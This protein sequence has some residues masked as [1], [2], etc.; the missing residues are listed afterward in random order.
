MLAL[1][2]QR[3]LSD[4]VHLGCFIGGG[5]HVGRFGKQLDLQR[6]QVTEDPRDRDH[7]VDARTTQFLDRH[8]RG[9][10]DAAVAVKARHRT[11]QRQSL[12]KRS[13]FRFQIVAAPQDHRDGLGQRIAALDI[14]IEQTLC[15][16]RS[17]AHRKGARDAEGIK[18]VNIAPGR[19]YVGG[20]QDVATRRR[21]DE[22]SVE[23]SEN[24]ADLMILR[25]QPVRFGERREQLAGGII[26]RQ[27]RC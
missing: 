24:R 16:G 20:V 1:I 10:C 14:G 12:R 15:L 6:H 22:T 3:M 8:Q 17:I 5:G 26:D 27:A 21:P 7:H 23:R 2:S 25:Q 19:Q 9:T 11:H 4:E 18:T 13:A